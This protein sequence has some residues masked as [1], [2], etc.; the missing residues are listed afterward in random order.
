M[1]SHTLARN[2]ER[3]TAIL[4]QSAIARQNGLRKVTAFYKTYG[5]THN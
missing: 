4:M 5:N 1:M 3:L 2:A